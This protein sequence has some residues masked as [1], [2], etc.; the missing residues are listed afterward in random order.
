MPAYCDKKG[1]I[2][3]IPNCQFAYGTTRLSTS[4]TGPCARA[5]KTGGSELDF[6]FSKDYIDLAGMQRFW[7]TSTGK[8]SIMYDQSGNGR[9][10]SQ[11]TSALQPSIGLDALVSRPAVLGYENYMTSPIINSSSIVTNDFHFFSAFIITTLTVHPNDGY[12]LIGDPSL[13]ENLN[14]GYYS[15]YG[16]D[17]LYML[18]S[19]AFPA[20][21]LVS[22]QGLLTTN[23]YVV[24]THSRNG[25][26]LTLK[27]DGVI[28]NTKVGSA[29]PL[30]FLGTDQRYWYMGIPTNI[31]FGP[32]YQRSLSQMFFNRYLNEYEEKLV[33][34]YLLNMIYL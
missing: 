28:T 13:G 25:V 22:A 31:S 3:Q 27:K 26:N 24:I 19:G 17:K 10:V 15:L 11:S 20:D 12:A 5:W 14:V 34:N 16:D 9:D 7:G 4:Y 23:T 1:I 8:I 29:G 2:E 33:T 30:K 32:S 18:A 6:G 21:F